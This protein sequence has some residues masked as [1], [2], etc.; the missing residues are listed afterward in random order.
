MTC[1]NTLFA[2]KG[3]M[4]KP[5]FR[6]DSVLWLW[7]NGCR[8]RDICWYEKYLLIYEDIFTSQITHNIEKI[9]YKNLLLVIQ[10]SYF[11]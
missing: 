2:L 6:R 7:P 5:S 11:L 10:P 4:E 9:R 3:N 1:C 8:D